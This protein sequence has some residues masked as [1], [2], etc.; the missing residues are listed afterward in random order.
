MASPTKKTMTVRNNRDAK[1]RANRQ[2]RL[3]R[4]TAK[5]RQGK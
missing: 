5:A 2:K 3:S 4:E 1:L